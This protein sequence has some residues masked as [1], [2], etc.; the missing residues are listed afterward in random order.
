MN[1]EQAGE[2]QQK[3]AAGAE[4][5]QAWAALADL[6]RNTPL[7]ISSAWLDEVQ[8]RWGSREGHLL[9]RVP[10]GTDPL[11]MKKK[12]LPVANVFFS[13]LQGGQGRLLVEYPREEVDDDLRL[14]AERGAY[15]SIVRP[16]KLLPVS[17][18]MFQHWL[19]VLQPSAFWVVLAMRQ[20]AF[21]SRATASQ[22]G[23]RIS[24]RDLARWIPMHYSSVRR[25]ILREGFLNWFF[26]QTKEAHDDLPPEYTVSVAYPLAPHH[27]A[28]VEE[29]LQKGLGEGKR[30]E[31]ILQELLELTREV[32][33]IR[34]G[35]L[36]YPGTYLEE[37]KSVLDLL[38]AYRAGK[39]N[40]AI[41]D[42]AQ[43][44]NR[45]I[46]RDYLTVSIPHYFLLR[47]GD[48]LSANEA[49]LIWYL[50]SLYHGKDE[51][52]HRFQ[53]YTSLARR[54]GIGRNTLQRYLARCEPP[55]E[56]PATFS[57]LYKEEQTLRNWLALRTL[58]EADPGQATEFEILPRSN[59]PIH[60]EDADRY[61]E[62]IERELRKI[63]RRSE[64]TPSPPVQSET[65]YVQ[66]ETSPE[67]T[68]SG[69]GIQTETGVEKDATPHPQS[70]TGAEQ[71]ET[72]AGQT[73]TLSSSKA[74]HLNNLPTEESVN[75]LSNL[76]NNQPLQP[77]QLD[78]WQAEENEESEGAGGG[79]VVNYYKLLGFDG[80][81]QKKKEKIIPDI[82][83][84]ETLFLA[85]LMRNHL[86]EA[87][88]PSRLA[89]RNMQENNTTESKYLT[90]AQKGWLRL[91]TL[92]HDEYELLLEREESQDIIRALQDTA[93]PGV[94]Q[95]ILL[96]PEK[97]RVGAQGSGDSRKETREWRQGQGAVAPL[98]RHGWNV[99]RGE[100]QREMDK[101]DFD[102]WVRNIRLVQVKDGEFVFETSNDYAREW[103]KKNLASRLEEKLA[104]FADEEEARVVFVCR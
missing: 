31:A 35:D 36:D 25:A 60:P 3:K 6:M 57:P 98:Y 71:S 91:R 68:P 85:W 15:E 2:A 56:Q 8:A 17:I 4:A 102:T 40:G 44:L 78:L 24:L 82:L 32:R 5:S 69:E 63:T 41:H 37:R 72:P 81:S 13:Q 101:V 104:P 97:E 7:D 12:F 93:F 73:E 23:K 66:K 88:F 84:R 96:E 79:V 48:A 30:M 90:L 49:A 50:R 99:V 65:G 10:Q 19:P 77:H 43:Q 42:L 21:V 61:R 26:T 53:G 1:H 54:V 20:T 87:N 18:Y 74:Q 52:A 70:A 75:Q 80:Y 33:A 100:L 29:F 22:V 28:W 51:S 58:E 46:T 45:E 27:L 76:S 86:T 14:K 11:W 94:L 39:V 55:E 67:E 38:A 92:L 59:E 95:D 9:L 34:P 64:T 16:E 103:L 83:Q 89:V 47:Y 62:L